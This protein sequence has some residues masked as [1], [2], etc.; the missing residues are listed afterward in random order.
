MRATKKNRVHKY[1]C[2]RVTNNKTHRKKIGY[3]GTVSLASMLIIHKFMTSLLIY[4]VMYCIKYMW[5][6]T[7]K[8]KV[9]PRLMP[10]KINP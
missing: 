9:Q 6:Y 4:A 2:S 3:D 5:L 1:T 7:P 8:L 10:N